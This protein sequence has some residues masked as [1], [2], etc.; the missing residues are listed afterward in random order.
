[1]KPTFSEA[2]QDANR[3]LTSHILFYETQVWFQSL[4]PRAALPPREECLIFPLKVHPPEGEGMQEALPKSIV[5]NEYSYFH[6]VAVSSA[7][8]APLPRFQKAFADPGIY[9][10]LCLQTL[11]TTWALIFCL[12]RQKS[13][14]F[15]CCSLA[16]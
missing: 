3:S 8:I 4:L 10:Q 15:C 7:V 16:L 14:E 12:C 6:R 13:P 5:C 9:L 2:S 1:V 11:V